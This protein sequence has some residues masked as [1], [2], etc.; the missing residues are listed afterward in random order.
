MGFFH[1]LTKFC[2]IEV[3]KILSSKFFIL[4]SPLAKSYR[5]FSSLRSQ[6]IQLEVSLSI[7][8]FALKKHTTGTSIFLVG[9][10]V[11]FSCHT[12]AV[13]SQW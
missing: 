2:S 3:W 12:A 10:S 5:F 11:Q 8:S 4:E 6:D 1:D 13:L 9:F 7:T